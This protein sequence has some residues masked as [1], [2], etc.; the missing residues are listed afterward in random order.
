MPSTPH[1]APLDPLVTE[2]V[3]AALDPYRDKMPPEDLEV[4]RL[5]L[6]LHYETHPEAVAL[7]NE[8]R[9]EQQEKE[10]R[11]VGRSGPRARPEADELAPGAPRKT[12]GGQGSGR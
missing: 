9:A 4:F 5:R 12:G 1:H 8:I 3:E 10:R 11:P 6:I 7:L 2:Y